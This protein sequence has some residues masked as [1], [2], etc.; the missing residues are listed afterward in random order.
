[1]AQILYASGEPF[2]KIYRAG[3]HGSLAF[4]L[5]FKPKKDASNCFYFEDGKWKMGY[6]M[7]APGVSLA[8]FV[9]RFCA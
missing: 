1:M 2:D 8:E 7:I 5:P 3:D 6:N 4:D 9:E